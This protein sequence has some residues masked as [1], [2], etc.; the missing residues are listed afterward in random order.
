MLDD[1][2]FKC[3]ISISVPLVESLSCVHVFRLVSVSLSFRLAWT[4]FVRLC[5]ASIDT[6]SNFQPSF[7]ALSLPFSLSFFNFSPCACVLLLIS[8]SWCRRPLGVDDVL[9]E[10]PCFLRLFTPLLFLSLSILVGRL[11]PLSF[12]SSDPSII[13]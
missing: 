5:C 10:F 12:G 2:K 4:C 7:L 6:C 13:E 11:D 9:L 3:F 8:C 1:E